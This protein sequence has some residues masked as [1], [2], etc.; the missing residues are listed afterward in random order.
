MKKNLQTI[1]ESWPKSFIRDDD[2]TQLLQTTDNARY[3]LV[4][5]SFKSGELMRL[6]KG[7]YLIAGKVK[8]ILPDEFELALL[9]YQ[10]SMISLESALSYHGLIPEAVYTT[11]S[12]SPKRAQEF[13]TPIGIFSYKRVPAKGFY[14]GVH[15]ISTPTGTILIASPWRALADFV[16]TR[17]KSW[18]NLADLEMD[19]RIDAET[20]INED[21]ETL[22]ILNKSY[23]SPRVRAQLTIFLNEIIQKR[24]DQ[25]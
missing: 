17:R 4:K 10:P 13:K 14:I 8:Q 16:Y 18:Q 21:Y 5:R 12:V 19:M 24:R 3:A 7:L 15:R 23:P 9:M 20:L 25:T 22:I 11:T 1:L 2:L 6:K